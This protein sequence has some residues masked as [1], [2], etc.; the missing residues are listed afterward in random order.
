MDQ[1]AFSIT[2]H[3][4]QVPSVLQNKQTTQELEVVTELKA[5]R[6]SPSPNKA[7]PRRRRHA[8]F[9]QFPAGVCSSSRGSAGEETRETQLHAARQEH[10]LRRRA[11]SSARGERGRRS[12]PT[13]RA[14]RRQTERLAPLLVSNPT[15][16]KQ[17]T[18]ALHLRSPLTPACWS[19]PPSYS[20]TLYTAHSQ[21]EASRE[22]PAQ[23]CTPTQRSVC[24]S[25]EETEQRSR[26]GGG[27]E[28]ALKTAT[29]REQRA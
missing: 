18:H 1:Q 12:G 20:L 5:F 14:C 16:S 8:P 4:S 24:V 21:S 27:V 13:S 23:S 25:N 28:R 22:T 11:A 17:N 19:P 26:A 6:D 29:G 2:Q 7:A 3:S 10:R 15:I 9:G